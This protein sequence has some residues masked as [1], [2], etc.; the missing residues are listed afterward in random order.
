MKIEHLHSEIV[1]RGPVFEVRKDLLRLPDGK[2]VTIDVID[3]RDSVTILPIDEQGNILFI[4][5]YR[6]PIKDYLLELPA[7]VSEA[8][9]D[10]LQCADRELREETG[11]AA[12]KLHKTG[13]FLSCSWLLE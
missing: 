1:Y 10:P 8:G 4:R 7:G 11:M 5:Q 6:Q 12:R 2:Q 13:D 3:H 9:E